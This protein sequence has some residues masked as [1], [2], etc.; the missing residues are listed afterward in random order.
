LAAEHCFVVVVVVVFPELE[1]LVTAAVIDVAVDVAALVA[2]VEDEPEAFEVVTVGTV[3]SSS[4]KI[5]V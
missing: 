2:A 5:S 4:M 1:V 3:V